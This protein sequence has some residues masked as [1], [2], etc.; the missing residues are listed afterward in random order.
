MSRVD[1]RLI[2]DF[3][4]DL[5]DELGDIDAGAFSLVLVRFQSAGFAA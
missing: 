3:D 1:K 5:H 4:E 2:V